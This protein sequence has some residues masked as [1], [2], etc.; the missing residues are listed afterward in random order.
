MK[1]IKLTVAYD[2]TEY[3]GWQ[4]Q[5]NAPTIE[6]ELDRAIKQLTGESLHVI[7]ASRTDAGVHAL[8]NVAV[9]DTES[10]IPGD[11]W[12]YAVNRYLPPQISVVDS[13]EVELN[14]HPRHC[15]TRKTYEYKILN[16]KFPIPQLRNYVWYVPGQ[17][18]IDLMRQA[19]ERLIGEHDYKSFCCVR[20]QAE[21]TVRTVYSIELEEELA[22]TGIRSGGVEPHSLR[23]E[24]A[25]SICTIGSTGAAGSIVAIGSTGTV[26][27]ICTTGS[28]DTIGNIGVAETSDDTEIGIDGGTSEHSENIEAG[29][30]G[31]TGELKKKN[32]INGEQG[33]DEGRIITI[34]ITGNGFLYNMVRII[35]G[36]LVQAGKGF[37]TPDDVSR[38]LE[39]C[40]R[41]AAGQTAPPQ[42]LTLVNIEYLAK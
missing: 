18:D 10:T 22:P 26:G 29:I 39:K 34:R 23:H 40:D 30:N 1:R 17:L 36:T 35:A 2:G 42:G 9:F 20:T 28:I 14:F 25:G 15:D 21:S 6:A 13:N 41:N 38:M 7:G 33:T 19:A 16:T 11:R 3:S 32:L 31:G 27:S 12:A 4:I 8:G 24:A 37:I 5:P